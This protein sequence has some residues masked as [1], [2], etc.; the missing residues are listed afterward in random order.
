M[1]APN[2]VLARER[3]LRSALLSLAYYM[4]MYLYI[5]YKYIYYI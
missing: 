3:T 2:V 4:S 5:L 1:L